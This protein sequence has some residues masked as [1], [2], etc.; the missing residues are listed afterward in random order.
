VNDPN[1][2]GN[3][4]FL[5]DLEFINDELLS[6]N[7][8]QQR[9]LENL[10]NN[11]FPDL[12]GSG[13]AAVSSFNR[14]LEEA[15]LATGATGAAIALVRGEKI[16]CHAT[17]GSHVPDIGVCLDPRHGL[18]GS[19]FQT[20]TLQNCSDTETDTRVDPEASRSLGAR[21]I[22]V[23]PLMDGDE[24]FGILEIFSSR[25]N[26]F[27][28][29]DLDALQ[30]LTER[31]V[32][33]KK[34]NPVTTATEPQKESSSVEKKLEEVVIPIRSQS[35]D[36]KAARSR[37]EHVSRRN[38]FT[39]IAL[40]TL[41]IA[42]AIL[43]GGLVG[44]RLG[45]QKATLGF[46]ASSPRYPANAKAARSDHPVSPA[47]SPGKELRPSPPRTDECGQPNAAMRPAQP[48]NGGLTVCQDGR[49]IFR[50]PPSAPPPTQGP[51]TAQSTGAKADPIPH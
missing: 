14:E 41:V 35:L 18:S 22:V 7:L 26:A 46:R 11:E 33:A 49:V 13:E 42:A 9:Q 29:S 45:W 24:L 17:V 43:L 31:I 39:G 16:V 47:V 19:C 4:E 40:G 20:R 3:P 10:S 5:K 8:R 48:R 28:Q 23:L 6:A 51:R 32:E 34:K 27:D 50:L 12:D 1:S 21:S 15:C 36:S 37:R 44:W 30:V 38:D 25:P 2:F